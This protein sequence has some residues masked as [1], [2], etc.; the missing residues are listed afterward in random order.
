M[1]STAFSRCGGLSDP[2]SRGPGLPIPISSRP[3]ESEP[4]V[5][6][7]VL[8]Q[9]HL[10][11]LGRQTDVQTA[12]IA[13]NVSAVD[14]HVPLR[15]GRIVCSPD[16]ICQIAAWEQR[17][18]GKCWLPEAGTLSTTRDPCILELYQP[19]ANRVAISG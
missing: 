8:H 11:A 7:S 15:Y 2:R 14:L 16:F 19:G 13:G 1:S 10:D 12:W 5:L 4:T 18:S 9:F 6:L 17:F 3:E